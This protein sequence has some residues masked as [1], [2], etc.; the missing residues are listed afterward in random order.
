MINDLRASALSPV[1][2]CCLM[3][4]LLQ[5]SSQLGA[6]PDT[7]DNLV[8]LFTLHNICNE[9]VKTKQKFEKILNSDVLCLFFTLFFSTGERKHIKRQKYLKCA[10]PIINS[11]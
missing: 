4:V 3:A 5:P 1:P 10:I 6:A 9:V 2:C 7:K 11:S 8:E